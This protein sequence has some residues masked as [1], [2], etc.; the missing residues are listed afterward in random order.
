[1]G[2]FDSPQDMK[3]QRFDI[4][5]TRS[6]TATLY[7]D[8]MLGFPDG[9][10]YVFSNASAV[11]FED[12]SGKVTSM[13]YTDAIA[14]VSKASCLKLSVDLSEEGKGSLIVVSSGAL[15]M[16]GIKDTSSCE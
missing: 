14:W 13:Q 5:G 1:M 12:H 9:P 4:D 15:S 10:A 16:N 8:Q 6:G 3:V 11:R 7:Q 2:I